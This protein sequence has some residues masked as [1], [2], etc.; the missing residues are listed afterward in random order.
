MNRTPRYAKSNISLLAGVV[1]MAFLAVALGYL[2]GSWMIQFV[3]GSKLDPV[4]QP[5]INEI[6]ISDP[7][8][9]E[10]D[11]LNTPDN[12]LT[13]DTRLTPNTNS[14]QSPEGLYVVQ[15]GAFNSLANAERLRSELLDKGYVSA[16]VTEGPPYKV[17]LRASETREE[18]DRLKDEVKQDGYVDVFIV[19]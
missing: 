7:S 10:A 13:P 17:Q 1:A 2:L 19:H 9:K 16:M 15:L 4:S 12:S 3:T 5:I 6:Q 14:V 8:D 11:P 18:A